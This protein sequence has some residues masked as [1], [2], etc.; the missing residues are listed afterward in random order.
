LV[1][2]QGGGMGRLIASGQTGLIVQ[3][4]SAESWAGTLREL[5]ASRERRLAMGQAA[6][7]CAEKELP[8]WEAVLNEDLL[9]VWRSAAAL[10]TPQ[11]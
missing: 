8:S 9:S 3:E 2:A 11:E 5:C 1:L 10:R 4:R 6:R 7:A